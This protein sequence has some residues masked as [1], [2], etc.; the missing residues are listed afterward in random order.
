MKIIYCDAC[1]E[2]IDGRVYEF[3]PLIHICETGEG[4]MGGYSD[5]NLNP[6]SGREVQYDLCLPCYNNIHLAAYNV[7]ENI[8]KTIGK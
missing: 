1:R 7:L 6:T 3:K 4:R 5:M 2:E 8:R